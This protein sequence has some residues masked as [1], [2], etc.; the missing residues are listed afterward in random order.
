MEKMNT[1]YIGIAVLGVLV[2]GF[3]GYRFYG[4]G[5]VPPSDVTA[6]ATTTDV[7]SEQAPVT[8]TQVPTK[9]APTP[10]VQ[11]PVLSYSTGCTSAVGTSTTTGKACD[12]SVKLAITTPTDLPSAQSGK[13]YKVSISTSGGP[14]EKVSYTWSVREEK[15]AFPVPGLGFSTIYGN[16]VSIVGTPADLYFDWIRTTK[17]VTFTLKV[18]VTAGTQSA[19]K[20]FKLVVEPVTTDS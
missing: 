19:A 4:A 17:P 13:P 8:N 14:A 9:P 20:Q 3:L 1:K 12:G 18:T 5:V 15:G 11:T 6:T 7:V 16:S 2:L 10:V